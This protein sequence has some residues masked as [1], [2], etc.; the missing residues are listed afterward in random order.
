MD[1]VRST[2]TGRRFERQRPA[3][4]WIVGGRSSA[5][6]ELL[7]GALHERGVWAELARPASLPSRVR[8]DDTV[9]GRLDI[10]PTLDGVEDGL[11][12]LCRVEDRGT[13]VLNP[14]PSLLAC[15]D[16]LQTAILL[17]QAGLPHPTTR[18]VSHSRPSVVLSHSR[19]GESM[20][21]A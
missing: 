15:H 4:V 16:K 11:W 7:L 6:N 1:G 2:F 19:S 14:A 17:A 12:A 9:L 8:R 5:T 10:R 13:R 21:G 18:H 3:A 20:P